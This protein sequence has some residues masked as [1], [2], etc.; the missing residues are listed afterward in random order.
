ME[1]SIGDVRA[2]ARGRVGARGRVARRGASYAPRVVDAAGCERSRGADG[3]R[4][5]HR[6]A[7]HPSGGLLVGTSCLPGLGVVAVLAEASG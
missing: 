4:A 3:E 5:A 6:Q 1:A 2:T 7:A